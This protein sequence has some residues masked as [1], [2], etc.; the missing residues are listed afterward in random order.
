[1]PLVWAGTSK[2]NGEEGEDVEH[3][4]NERDSEKIRVPVVS[5]LLFSLP[6]PC[7]GLDVGSSGPSPLQPLSRVLRL[8]SYI[9][10]RSIFLPYRQ[11][12]FR[13]SRMNRGGR[14]KQR[15]REKEKRGRSA[16]APPRPFPRCW[17][18]LYR[19]SFLSTLGVV[20]LAPFLFA[21]PPRRLI[22]VILWVF[23]Q[24]DSSSGIRRSQPSPPF[25]SE[26]NRRK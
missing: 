10:S 4:K 12:L 11:R 1:M 20:L 25:S 15:L 13:Q 18:L 22:P 14:K 26:R 16:G 19:P 23:F 3:K 24:A 17:C 7:V 8:V 6:A 2:G 5:C 21:V 9:R